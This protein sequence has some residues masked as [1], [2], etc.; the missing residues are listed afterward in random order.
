MLAADLTI[1]TYQEP[2]KSFPHPLPL[3]LFSSPL[4]LLPL[5]L[6]FLSLSP[7]LY[8]SLPLPVCMNVCV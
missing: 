5:F 1:P 6:F 2:P 8:P 3:P 7:S 4:L